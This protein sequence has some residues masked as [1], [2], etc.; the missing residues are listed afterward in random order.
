MTFRYLKIFK[1]KIFL[2]IITVAL[3]IISYFTKGNTSKTTSVL[4]GIALI[5]SGINYMIWIIKTPTKKER[6]EGA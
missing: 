1:K 4:A 6:D 3:I 5:Y 2:I